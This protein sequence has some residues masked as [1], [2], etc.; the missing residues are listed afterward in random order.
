MTRVRFG[1]TKECDQCGCLFARKG[2]LSNESWKKARFCGM[3]CL[4][5]WQRGNGAKERRGSSGQIG[6][7]EACGGTFWRVGSQSYCRDPGCRDE[8]NR[9]DAYAL[10]RERA[11]PEQFE[12]FCAA[13]R[14]RELRLLIDDQA[15]DAR[16]G[17]R[18]TAEGGRGHYTLIWIPFD[19]IG[20]TY[21]QWMATRARA[22]PRRRPKRRSIP[23]P[24]APVVV[25]RMGVT[26]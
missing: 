15:N 4:R 6:F 23:P 7:C 24:V 3:D 20:E 17:W 10:I 19:E 11:T 13:E 8:R 1:E 14:E 9:R 12:A 25:R 22:R 26:A 16:H 2:G 5:A 18:A 21:H